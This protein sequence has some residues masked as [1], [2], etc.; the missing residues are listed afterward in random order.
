M[1]V[2]IDA[3]GRLVIPKPLRERIGLTPGT[4]LE[5]N[6]VG[7]H[8][9]VRPAGRQVRIELVG[10]RPVARAPEDSPVLTA[11]EVRGLIERDRR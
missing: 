2:T 8:L 9:E 7:D 4:V 10:G 1:Q 5:L 3:A 11:E 6:E